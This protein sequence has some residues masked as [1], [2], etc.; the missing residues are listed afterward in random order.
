MN[1]K[2][3]ESFSQ[4]ENSSNADTNKTEVKP[5]TPHEWVLYIKQSIDNNFKGFVKETVELIVVTML[6]L[7]VIRWGLAEA[8]YIPSGSMEPTLQI[9]DRLLIEKLTM[10]F[11]RQ[12]KR[13]D[14]MVFYPPPAVLGGKDLSYDP[15]SVLGRLT[16]LPIFPSENAFIK[17][18]IGLPG[19]H[20][21]VK[22]GIGVFVNGE[23][24]DESNYIKAKPDYDLNVLGDIGGIVG[25]DSPQYYRPYGDPEHANEP[26]IV[27]P[28]HLFMMG[29]NRNN[30][31]DGHIW[32][33]LDQNRLIGRTCLLFWRIFDTPTYKNK[34]VSL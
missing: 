20:I 10:R 1:N 22:A 14:I 9:G 19:D 17:R 4:T 27:P 3:D 30:S 11:G 15:I 33:F 7:I 26:I 2:T 24:L 32:G 31:L 21:R 23:L 25:E 16:G 8:R 13:G 6:L 12:P 29:D 5:K 34:N 28:G 18:V